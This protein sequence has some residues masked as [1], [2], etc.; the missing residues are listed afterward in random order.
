MAHTRLILDGHAC[1]ST[2]S[3]AEKCKPVAHINAKTDGTRVDKRSDGIQC[4]AIDRMPL[5]R[6]GKTS[7][8]GT[9]LGQRDRARAPK[10]EY[11]ADQADL[12]DDHV[13]NGM[14][15]LLF[16]GNEGMETAVTTG[17]KATEMA[18]ASCEARTHNTN[19]IILGSIAR[20]ECD[21][22]RPS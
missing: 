11:G 1:H 14:W 6:V 13:H 8:T 18:L 22:H 12:S 4:T 3:I 7:D 9:D 16:A 10:E 17:S 21:Q 20:D 2:P 15:S 5:Q 19:T